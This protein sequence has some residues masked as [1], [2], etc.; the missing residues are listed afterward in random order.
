MELS[1]PLCNGMKDVKGHCPRCNTKWEDGGMVNNYLGPYSPYEDQ[2]IGDV[3]G[4]EDCIHLLYC[5]ICGY[6]Q[7]V[8]VQK[9][10]I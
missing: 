6:D 7:R 1:C 5:P 9:I 4:G 2:L 10:T 3:E 8:G